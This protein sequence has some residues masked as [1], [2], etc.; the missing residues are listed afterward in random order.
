MA[1][2][3]ISIKKPEKAL[4]QALAPSTS[5]P[6]SIPCSYQ[7]IFHLRSGE[8]YAH[9]VLWNVH[10]SGVLPPADDTAFCHD[11]AFFA[12][13][14]QL[15]TKADDLM[16]V[17]PKV[18]ID[19]FPHPCCTS[20]LLDCTDQFCR[21]SRHVA[22]SLVFE[23][24]ETLIMQPSGSDVAHKL[25]QGGFSIAVVYQEGDWTSLKVLMDLEPDFVVAGR[26]FVN[27]LRKS[28]KKQIL[29]S[30]LVRFC[31]KLG[32]QTIGAGIESHGEL[33]TL[34]DMKVDLVEGPYLS[35][36]ASKM[37]A[38]YPQARAK[39]ESLHTMPL[40]IPSKSQN[41]LGSLATYVPPIH[42]HEKVLDVAARM[43]RE[44]TLA[45]YP[46]VEN[47]RP[48]GLIQKDKLF[49]KLGR[50]YGCAL[51]ERKDVTKI[52]DKPLVFE[53]DTPLERVSQSVTARDEESI[54]DA[55]IVTRNGAYVGIVKVHQILER[56]TEL[57]IQMAVQANPLTG[58]PGNNVIREEIAHRLHN[59]ILF[60]VGYAD[61]DHFKPFNDH[62]GFD[63][64]DEVIRLVGR[65]LRE[66][67]SEWDAEG[68][69]GHIGGDDFVFI[70]RPHGVDG[71]C[72]TILARFEKA[73]EVFYDAKT[74]EAK[75]YV[76][77]DRQGHP[78]RFPLPSL[79]IAVVTNRERPFQ[80]C[81]HV[82]SVASE[83]KHAVKK[84]PGNA[85]LVDRRS[86]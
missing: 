71:L 54:Y 16:R 52:M 10:P 61:V 7:P 59:G 13:L 25:K 51:Y 67:V 80:S 33:E 79:S 41:V 12:P 23:I 45:A 2:S 83:V 19:P 46:V 68:F 66:A 34:W 55:V 64:G 73:M 22:P 85:F 48:V 44:G 4:A 18:F 31:R 63:K 36:A 62:F 86:A 47:E 21:T 82:A 57:K 74:L 77:V 76:A 14:A 65:I 72:R 37:Q 78:T 17:C 39:I 38:A 32:A 11:A 81:A 8:L 6:L 84:M 42:V 20:R 43:D 27:G 75:S 5:Q 60:A 70:V 3:N 26:C 69:V 30:T 9:R 58:L 53:A 40:G 49:F 28:P 15:V 24:S 35:E 1:T 56:L 50:R 29:L